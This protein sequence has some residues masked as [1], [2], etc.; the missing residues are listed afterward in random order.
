MKALSSIRAWLVDDFAW[1]IFSLILAVAIWL[2]VHRIVQEGGQ[3]DG[4]SGG[5]T[6]TYGN[7]P[8]FI[9]SGQADVRDYKLLQ[10]TVSVT[11]SGSAEAI[12]RL[13]ANQ[14]H[15]TVNLADPGIINSEKHPVEIAVPPGITVVSVNPDAIGIIAPP[16]KE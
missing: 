13:Q 1:K 10:P 7:L 2:T 4:T 5:S 16:P 8:V 15:A 14:I 3:A 12:G 9:V 11:V 6:L